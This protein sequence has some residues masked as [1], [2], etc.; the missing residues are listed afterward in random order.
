VLRVIARLNVGGPARQA[1]S[2][3]ARL[4]DRGYATVLLHGDLSRGEGDMSHLAAAAGVRPVRVPGLRR[5]LGA[6]DVVALWE[7]ARWM[8]RLRPRVLHTHTAK[9]GAIGRLA[10]IVSGHRPEAVV[11]TFHG[12]VFEGEFSPRVSAAFARLERLLARRANRIIAVSDQV[13]DDLVALG[14]APA[15]R[16]EVIRLGFDLA[17]FVLDDG[18]EREARR[19]T[20][21][22]LGIAQDARVVAVLA[23]VVRVK[24]IDR[25][26]AMARLLAESH[27]DVVFLVVGDGDRR[28]TLEASADARALGSRLVWAG[29][30]RDIP[31][32]CFASDVV[33][34][35]SD[36]EGTPVALIEAQA[37]RRP[38]VTTN[39]GGV[40]TAVLDGRTGTIVARDPARL[41]AAVAGYLDDPARSAA[42]GS[43][44]REHV[45]RTF[46]LERL[47]DRIDDLY[48][49]LL[50]QPAAR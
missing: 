11:Q 37:A 34:L 17:P 21:E 6:H 5:E 16:I 33:A 18:A 25:F 14:I 47:T 41:A 39:V 12:Q 23:R 35:T 22:R 28:P 38:V 29:F 13:R 19:A 9:A 1:V 44:G 43:A 45:L 40:E 4:R 50:T 46:S 31:A 3:T 15:E 8:R 7:V 20:R 36:N 26:L 2:L 32:I 27:P 48:S 49:R 30:E 42:V 24:R 10:T